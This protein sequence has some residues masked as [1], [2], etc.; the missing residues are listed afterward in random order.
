MIKF[1][2]FSEPKKFVWIIIKWIKKQFKKEECEFYV[3][4]MVPNKP[5]STE[6]DDTISFVHVF[7][8]RFIQ[9]Y[10]NTYDIDNEEDYHHFIKYI[11]HIY[12]RIFY[13]QDDDY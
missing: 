6:G 1:K 2:N 13:Q 10:Q 3:T 4:I 11:K 9:T 7:Q 12:V 5:V 8:K